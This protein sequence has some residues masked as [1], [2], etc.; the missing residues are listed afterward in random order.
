MGDWLSW[1]EHRLCKPGVVGSSPTFSTMRL[2]AEASNGPRRFIDRME[3]KR[4]IVEKRNYKT[5]RHC[6]FIIDEASAGAW[7]G[8][9]AAG[10]KRERA[11]G[12]CLWL[13]EAKKG[14]A[15]SDIPRGGASSHGSA[16]TRMGQPAARGR[17]THG[18]WGRTRRTET[19]K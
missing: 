12:G 10:N 14:A 1:L 2:G 15:G 7:L 9:H 16:G 13:P 4:D 11:H 6:S 18:M 3:G 8:S 19:S 17:G 5:T